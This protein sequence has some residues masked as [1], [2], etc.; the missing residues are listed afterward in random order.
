ML[1]QKKISLD[2]ELWNKI[3]KGTPDNVARRMRNE[4]IVEEDEGEGDSKEVR[5]VK[6]RQRLKVNAGELAEEW[7]VQV[8]LMKIREAQEKAAVLHLLIGCGIIF[9]S[10][11]I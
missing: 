1:R 9:A 5:E 10:I 11:R 7:K 6:E 4:S 8:E 2:I 3:K